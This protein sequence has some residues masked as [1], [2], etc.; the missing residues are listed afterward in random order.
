MALNTDYAIRTGSYEP[1]SGTLQGGSLSE[2]AKI[3][4]ERYDNV[5]VSLISEHRSTIA[6]HVRK[7]LVCE[8]QF[9]RVPL[10]A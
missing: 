8:G 7:K 9:A 5:K 2:M 10:S 4:Q 1:E 3:A 6:V